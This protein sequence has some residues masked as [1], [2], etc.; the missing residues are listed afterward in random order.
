MLVRLLPCRVGLDA[1][2]NAD[3][4]PN[5]LADVC[6][7]P[8]GDTAEQR[9]AECRSLLDN[10]SFE[11]DAEYRRHDSHPELAPRAPAGHTRG[12]DL[13]AELTHQV[14]RVA[15]PV[16]DAFEHRAHERTAVVP[17]RE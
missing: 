14:E 15:Q 17:E 12:L 3:A 10:G 9:C 6:E 1:I 11:R 4:R 5:G 8:R 16:C 2:A 7:H 13:H